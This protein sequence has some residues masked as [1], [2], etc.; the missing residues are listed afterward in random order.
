MEDLGGF[1]LYCCSVL[2]FISLRKR[3]AFLFK[4]MEID[5]RV[6]FAN[7]F[8]KQAQTSLYVKIAS[9]GVVFCPWFTTMSM[10]TKFRLKCLSLQ[11]CLHD[12]WHKSSISVIL[13]SCFYRITLLQVQPAQ[14]SYNAIVFAEMNT[15][16]Q[17]FPGDSALKLCYHLLL[18]A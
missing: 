18:F 6:M 1:F 7:Y 4:N 15:V 14:E 10:Y 12:W 11:L 8:L 2:F 5:I 9:G 16:S 13:S 17:R 3:V